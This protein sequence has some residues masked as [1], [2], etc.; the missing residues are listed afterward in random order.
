MNDLDAKIALL[1]K[2]A[3]KANLDRLKAIAAK[4]SQE[5]QL[6]EAWSILREKYGASSLDD[7]KSVLQKSKEELDSLLQKVTED[8]R[9][10]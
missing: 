10:A 6:A 2:A 7:V 9:R 5:Q 1:K 3:E 4:E 8:L